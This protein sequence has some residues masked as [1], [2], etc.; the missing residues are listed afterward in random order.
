MGFHEPATARRLRARR[1]PDTVF[2]LARS[3]V[4]A[5]VARLAD[6]AMLAEM[7]SANIGGQLAPLASM[8]R[9]WRHDPESFWIFRHARQRDSIRGAGALL[10]LNAAGLAALRNGELDRLHPQLHLLASAGEEPAAMYIWALIARGRG[11]A[12]WAALCAILRRERFV[13]ADYFATAA[14]PDGARTLV[15]FGFEP[16]RD[17]ALPLYRFTRAANRVDVPCDGTEG[18]H[19]G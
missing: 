4:C 11:A 17:G 15:N 5:D 18:A 3:S 12:G 14:T 16:E 10:H 7:A 2:S 19:A 8:Q 13:R 9:V 6:L 1:T